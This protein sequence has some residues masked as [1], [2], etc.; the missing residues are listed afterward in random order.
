VSTFHRLLNEHGSA[1]DAL[2]ALP[3]VARAAGVD[4]YAPCPEGGIHNEIK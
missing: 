2:A 1:A 4:D 3:D